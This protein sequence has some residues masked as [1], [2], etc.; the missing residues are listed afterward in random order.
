MN[1]STLTAVDLSQKRVQ[2]FFET[3]S[4]RHLN[5][6]SGSLWPH[7]ERHDGIPSMLL[8]HIHG[9]VP[10]DKGKKI[11]ITHYDLLLRIAAGFA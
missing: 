2:E 10:K 3:V 5:T 7:I 11:R 8:L 4:L 1:S 6:I 9:T